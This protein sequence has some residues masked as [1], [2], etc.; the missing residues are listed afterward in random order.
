M[1]KII[2]TD[3][4]KTWDNLNEFTII[5]PAQY[6]N[7]PQW[8]HPK[9]KIVNLCRKLSSQALGGTV[10]SFATVNGQKV[11]PHVFHQP[12]NVFNELDIS[13][14][15]DAQIS[16]DHEYLFKCGL[17]IFFGLTA[18]INHTPL[19]IKA[20]QFYP[21]PYLKLTFTKDGK[22]GRLIAADLEDIEGKEWEFFVQA[23][24]LYLVGKSIGKKDFKKTKYDFAIL[25]EIDNAQNEQ[26]TEVIQKLL[27]RAEKRGL[28]S[29]IITINDAGKI[30]QFDALL[31]YTSSHT[32]YN[33][34]SLMTWAESHG[35]M[36][37]NSTKVIQRSQQK[38]WLWQ[39]MQKY[40]TV[41][42]YKYIDSPDNLPDFYPLQLTDWRGGAV[43]VIH[44]QQELQDKI[45]MNLHQE[46]WL[47]QQCP[48][49]ANSW[50]MCLLNDEIINIYRQNF[51]S[52][53]KIPVSNPTAQLKEVG[54]AV[55]KVL[56]DGFYQVVL[57]ES[58]DQF[59]FQGVTTDFSLIDSI[60]KNM[61]KD[62]LAEKVIEFFLS[63]LE[64]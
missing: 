52:D 63:R 60:V 55:H 20:F 43:Q 3:L 39:Q 21:Y 1:T 53:E 54:K 6:L 35:V 48:P 7:D 45:E 9:I 16:K 22:P 59:F 62:N 38:L 14:F 18:D 33:L 17:N 15:S 8:H 13:L 2:V 64:G 28:N 46:N 34:L 56:G 12:I 31:C 30:P 23:L 61:L 24:R 29:E 19:G 5:T 10:S 11:I 42:P 27:G 51:K 40:V 37:L 32:A 44:H 26:D 25:I 58:N 57:K 4:K 47:G 50:Y 36:V 49:N 41:L